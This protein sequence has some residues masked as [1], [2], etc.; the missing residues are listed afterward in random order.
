M[1][2]GLARLTESG[3]ELV[4]VLGYPTYYP[5]FGFQPAGP[6][7]LSAP[8][9]IPEEHSDDWM[10]LELLEGRVGRIRGEVTC[11]AALDKP[12]HWRE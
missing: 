2:R 5:R 9:P 1:Q 3:C 10:V 8:Y 11:A 6:A 7:G 4:F 12:E